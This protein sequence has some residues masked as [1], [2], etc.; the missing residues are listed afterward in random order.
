[1]A[2]PLKEETGRR[3]F[4]HDVGRTISGRDGRLLQQSV[5]LFPPLCCGLPPSTVLSPPPPKLL[6][7]PFTPPSPP[8]HLSSAFV[9]PP[10]RRLTPFVSHWSPRLRVPFFLFFFF[11]ARMPSPPFA[12]FFF[13]PPPAP[14]P[15][16]PT[17]ARVFRDRGPILIGHRAPTIGSSCA[18]PTTVVRHAACSWGQ[19]RAEEK[20]P[21]A[22]AGR[23]VTDGLFTRFPKTG[24][25]FRS[26]R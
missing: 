11:C 18:A 14:T 8:P 10:P 16:G 21:F 6:P 5:L 26:S 17:L 2:C 3:L 13:P 15:F 7:P 22:G 19:G 9:T 4:E 25:F 20:N 1:M 12:F 23:D 24:F